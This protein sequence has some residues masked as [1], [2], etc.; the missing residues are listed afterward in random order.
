MA[1]RRCCA[2]ARGHLSA[3]DLACRTRKST[4]VTHDVAIEH[5]SGGD[6]DQDDEYDDANGYATQSLGDFEAGRVGLD[7][8]ETT[9]VCKTGGS[10]IGIA[11]I[12]DI[13]PV[14]G[15]IRCDQPLAFR[16]LGQITDD[17]VT[18]RVENHEVA[19]FRNGRVADVQGLFQGG[20]ILET[21]HLSDQNDGPPK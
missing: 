17:H 3:R 14:R 13:D 1:S 15:R 10:D 7:D 21:V 6:T 16:Y 18:I 20:P 11:P 8:D 5:K 4:D 12:T 9:A 2:G 19:L